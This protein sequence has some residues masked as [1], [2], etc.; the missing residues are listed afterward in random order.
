[1]PPAFHVTH[2]RGDS[3]VPDDGGEMRRQP[4]TAHIPV[5]FLTSLV[6]DTEISPIEHRIGGRLFLSK[7]FKLPDLLTVIETA[8][9]TPLAG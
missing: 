6:A 4:A 1:M 9:A 8:L 2:E 3:V 7:P 5:V